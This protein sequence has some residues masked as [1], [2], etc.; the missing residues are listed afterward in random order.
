ML[1]FWLGALCLGYTMEDD[2]LTA[3][4][5]N[6]WLALSNMYTTMGAHGS[7]GSTKELK[8]SAV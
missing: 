3:H 5:S 7:L 1:V 8:S 4:R 2:P 6:L